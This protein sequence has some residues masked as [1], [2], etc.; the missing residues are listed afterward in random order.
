MA[1]LRPRGIVRVGAAAA[2]ATVISVALSTAPAQAADPVPFSFIAPPAQTLLPQSAG[3]SGTAFR[4]ITPVILNEDPTGSL[5][6]VTIAL[7]AT[8]LAP[9]AELSLPQ[10]CTFT[11]PAHLHASCSLGTVGLFGQLNLGI[12]ATASAAVGATGSLSYKV[13][14]AN[15]IEDPQ[16]GAV[17]TTPVVIGD[18]PDLAVGQL[19]A[20]SVKPGGSVGYTPQVSN[21]GDR[22]AK[23][24]V[25]YL[26]TAADSGGF[27][28]AVGGNYSNC[29]YGVGD[30]A[31]PVAERTGV[32]CRFDDVVV[33]PGEILQPSAPAV[34][35]ATQ[36]ATK[37]YV[38]YGFDVTGG[39]L[40]KQTPTG[41]QGTGGKLLLVPAPATTKSLVGDIDYGNNVAISAISTGQV[42]DVAAV[43]GDV[44]GTVGRQAW[45]T[46]GVRNAGTL[47][48]QAIPGA[49][50]KS[51][52]ADVLVAL[53]KGVTV[54]SVPQ[55]CQSL[56][57][58]LTN[59][60]SSSAASDPTGRLEARFRSAQAR[61]NDPTPVLDP[62]SAYVCLVDRVL[63][64]GQSASFR[65]GLKPT[66]VLDRAEGMVIAVAG[67]G[68]DNPANDIA[69][70]HV[71]ATKAVGSTATPTAS[72]STSAQPGS[73]ASP[74]SGGGGLAQTGGGSAATPIALGG[75]AAV[76][77][78]AGAV[79]FAR[80]R[81]ASSHS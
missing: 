26:D 31:T 42:S 28:F 15:G 79:L 2:A 70:F 80:R 1:H 10:S 81:R 62:G 30:S 9:V 43:A 71:T 73:S 37:G 22:D 55:G 59:S 40:D 5:T 52:T 25:M 41:R 6:G 53:P 19:G 35:T 50:S 24:V 67:K 54:T 27:D 3:V 21:K 45:W 75:A 12:R 7:D 66:Q 8:K 65:F 51:D 76:A 23:G 33:H 72:P 39:E 57:L 77:L 64:P 38:E 13:T 78:G 36:Q 49:P 69:A 20:L 60:R 16:D 32:L 14:A 58:G 74:T 18:G 46:A 61:P 56:G 29:Q 44:K 63:Q 34:V 48:T 17:Q 47:P 4:T 11:D 68:D